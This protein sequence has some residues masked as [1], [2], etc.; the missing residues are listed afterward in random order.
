MQFTQ[1]FSA[2]L[3][4][5]RHTRGMM[6]C[7][8]PFD[9]IEEIFDTIPV[10]IFWKDR[11][12]RFLGC[13]RPFAEDA[14]IADPQQFI[15][16]TDFY[17]YH[18][19]QAKAFRDDDANVMASGLPK[20]GIIEKIVRDD[21]GVIWLETNKMP[22]RDSDGNVIG[23]IGMYVDVT[24]RILARQANRAQESAQQAA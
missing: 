9:S 1:S 21:G 20:L 24:D 10:R 18:P 23:V 3:P 2:T 8:L 11:D 7:S 15:G 14:G 16:K 6:I 17:F 13:N 4:K 5:P 12:S 19:E 22:M